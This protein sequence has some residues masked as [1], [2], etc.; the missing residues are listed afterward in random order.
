[1]P[2]ET[3]GEIVGRGPVT[4]PGYYGR[5]D[6]TAEILRGGWLYG[7]DIGFLDGDG[8]L[9][10]VDR[11]KDL[12]ISG[13]VNVYP[14]DIEEVAVRHPAV[15]DVAVFGVA[16]DRWGEPPMSSRTG[17]T[18]ECRRGTSAS[19]KSSCVT[20]SRRAPP[21]RRC[22]G[23]SVR[24][25]SL[26]QRDL[27]HVRRNDY[28]AW[29][30]R[31]SLQVPQALRAFLL[32][33]RGAREMLDD[34]ENP[35]RVLIAEDEAIIRL[36]LRGILEKYGLIVVAEARNGTEAVELARAVRPDVALLDLRM[37]EL[38][39]IEAARRMYAERPLPI[40][41]LTAFSDR[42][43]V[44]QAIDAGVFTYL[45]KPFKETDVVPAIRAAAARHAELLNA[46]RAVGVKPLKPIFLGL[47]S[48]G[49]GTWS[50]R[51]TRRDD[52][53]LNVQGIDA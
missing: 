9:H 35:L 40:I 33:R 12:I 47:P 38:D 8:F 25:T 16:D 34:Y 46:R 27:A 42:A 31:R 32:V 11:K 17:S 49:G 7:G 51:M 39:G 28:R 26:E 48:Q 53:T 52:G 30:R 3:V 21:A 41:M 6:L 2:P 14:R 10:L 13:G 22:G 19:A 1:V 29:C 23:R 36:D 4:M 43:N 18:N 24:S 20:P 45:V 50:V 15:L 37:P 44:E 5:P